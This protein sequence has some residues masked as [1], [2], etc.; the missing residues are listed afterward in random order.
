MHTRS[1][2][3]VRDAD[4]CKLT[5]AALAIVRTIADW[6]D[7]DTGG[8]HMT[9]RN[10]AKH[11]RCHPATVERLIPKLIED[12]ELG[13][14]IEAVSRRTRTY[15]VVGYE[16]EGRPVVPPS[17]TTVRTGG[18]DPI[19]APVVAL[20]ASTD[21]PPVLA[22]NASTD[23]PVDN[24][25]VLASEGAGARI[26]APA[27]LASEQALYRGKLKDVEV[28]EVAAPAVADP[29]ADAVGDSSG[30][31]DAHQRAGQALRGL[32]DSLKTDGEARSRALAREQL[33]RAP[34]VFVTTVV[35][36]VALDVVI[37]DPAEEVA[38]A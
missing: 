10:I 27:V 26:E 3:Y 25:L 33:G 17:E 11:A 36:T 8:C 16:R 38:A 4:R 12:G 6:A 9:H 2:L 14:L 35:R 1:L 20:D 15:M 19:L 28:L 32:I 31:G 18:L 37:V 13:I 30:N 21:D 29:P 23:S 7:R 5:G 24:P 34:P 22:P